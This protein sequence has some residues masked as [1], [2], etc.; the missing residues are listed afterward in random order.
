[1]NLMVKKYD[2]DSPFDAFIAFTIGRM[3]PKIPTPI[4]VKMPKPNKS[5]AGILSIM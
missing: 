1:M 4:N 2:G 5:M 3:N